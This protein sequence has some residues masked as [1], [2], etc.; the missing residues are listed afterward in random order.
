MRTTID[1]EEALLRDLRQV[2]K[3][4]G[5]AF[6]QVVNSALRRG[7]AT[8]AAVATPRREACFSFSLGRPIPPSL[9]LD[10][11]LVLAEA[12]EDEAIFRKLDL[13]K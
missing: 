9:D 8:R 10:K 5:I 13:R 3:D 11:A 4:S 1:I 6:K 12:L 7:L 2:A